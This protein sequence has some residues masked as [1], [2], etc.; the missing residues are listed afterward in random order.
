MRCVALCLVLVIL[1]ATPPALAAPPA[2]A[3]GSVRGGGPDLRLDPADPHAGTGPAGENPA[4]HPA[5]RAATSELDDPRPPLVFRG[6]G[7]GHGVGMSQYGAYAQSIAGR[8]AEEILRHYYQGVE[9]EQVVTSADDPIR[10][11]LLAGRDEILLRTAS[12]AE[13]PPAGGIQ[14]GLGGQTI[15]VPYDDGDWSVRVEGDSLAL[16]DGAGQ[17]RATGVGPA[18]V[19]AGD[20]PSLLRL[21][22][23][24]PAADR[25]RS[26][27][28]LEAAGNL[29]ATYRRGE[30]EISRHGGGVRAVL[31]LPLEN[32]LLGLAEVPSSWGHEENGGAAALEA[33]AI[34]GRTYATRQVRGNLDEQCACHLGATPAH[35]VYAGWAKEGDPTYG[36]YWRD[37]VRG[38]AGEVVTYDGALAWTYYSSSHGGRSENVEDSWAYGTSAIDYLRSV[39]D[40]WSL[41]P[42]VGNARAAWDRSAPNRAFANWVATDPNA[43]AELERVTRVRILDRTDGGTPRTLAVTGFDASGS[44]VTVNVTGTTKGI[45]G[46]SLLRDLEAAGGGRLLPSQQL[47]SIGFPPFTDDDGSVHELGIYALHAAGVVE[48]ASETLFAPGVAMTRGQMATLLSEALD[49]P[50]A[51][52]QGLSDVAGTTHAGGINA[53]VAAGVAEGFADGTFR[54]NDPVSRGQMATLLAAA[55]DLPPAGDQGFDD[56]SGNTHAD[57]INAV[58]AAGV[59]RGVT[60]TA[61]R[62]RSAVTRGQMATLLHQALRG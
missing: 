21:P 45:A 6:S 46:A 52:D 37:A 32:Y 33:Q 43:G 48:G 35:Q 11:G 29:T 28:E 23:L 17:V 57:G 25:Q 44:E 20:N 8:S 36:R 53:V 58:A 60:E 30:L 38:T 10:V 47:R 4:G 39:D 5:A 42:A 13:Q 1:L 50:A 7:W 59:A 27:P 2:F 12:R 22:Q 18:V 9:V 3:D 26:E 16:F 51:G 61:F 49:L 15:T 24:L 31:E 62:P 56:V 14:V 19:S 55:F 40:P 41:D 54:P 34:A